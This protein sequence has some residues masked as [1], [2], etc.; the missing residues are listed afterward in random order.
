MLLTSQ[1][2]FQ[3]CL[4]RNEDGQ[5][6]AQYKNLTFKS[7][8]Q[9]IYLANRQMVGVEALLRIYDEKAEPIRPDLYFSSES[10]S[11]VDKL[12][13]ERLSRVIHIRNFSQSQYRDLHLFL[14]VL[15]AAGEH[16]AIE[17]LSNGL[18]ANRLKDLNIQHS[19][20]VMEIVE[21]TA[22]NESLLKIA[23]DRLGEFGFHIAVDDYGINASNRQRVEKFKP[24]IIKMDRSLLVDF[25][26]GKRAALNSGI[27]LARRLGSKVVIEGI[28]THEQL[29]AM[30]ELGVEYYQG[31][32]LATPHPITPQVDDV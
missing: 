13:V 25:M 5:Y 2:D 23:I 22:Q 26:Q 1:Q 28:E 6:V 15:P 32:F 9:P 27:A 3:R 8:Y 12:N 29:T 19:Q 7:V 4:T 11:D 10:I 17:D 14:N 31:Y 24:D 21:L 18:L 30:L 20:L 16:L